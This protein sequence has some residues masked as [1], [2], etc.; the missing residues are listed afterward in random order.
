MALMFL[1][2]LRLPVQYNGEFHNTMPLFRRIQLTRCYDLSESCFQFEN[3]RAQYPT[4]WCNHDSIMVRT[5]K[6]KKK[7]TASNFL[8]RDTYALTGLLE[9]TTRF[10]WKTI[11]DGRAEQD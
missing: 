8:V 6:K 2:S 5:E 3:C 7:N 9:C 10:R 11:P 1:T 4:V